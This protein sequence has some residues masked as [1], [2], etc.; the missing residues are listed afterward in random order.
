MGFFW[1]LNTRFKKPSSSS[2]G[3]WFFDGLAAS[4]VNRLPRK[5]NIHSGNL[6][7]RWLE[8]GPGLKMY[9]L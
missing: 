1:K 6:T 4:L 2:P 7:A 5:E 3:G 8:N 9:F